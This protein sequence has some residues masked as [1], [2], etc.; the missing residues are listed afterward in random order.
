MSTGDPSREAI[1]HIDSNGDGQPESYA[2]PPAIHFGPEGAIERQNYLLPSTTN[3]GSAYTNELQT[4]SFSSPANYGSENGRGSPTYSI[5][6]PVNYDPK[7]ADV[8]RT[9]SFSQPANIGS[10]GVDE[11]VTYSSP[12]FG[13]AEPEDI[14]ES[15]NYS[16]PPHANH[17]FE[18]GRGS[19]VLSLPPPAP[20]SD[21]SAQ[22]GSMGYEG[23][24]SQIP[25]RF[26]PQTPVSLR[27]PQ[28][29]AE[30]STGSEPQANT[31]PYGWMS[32]IDEHNNDDDLHDPAKPMRGSF[33][34]TRAVVNVGTLILLVL[35]LLML[36]AGYPILH[37]YT[38]D[39]NDDDRLKSF[40]QIFD[41]ENVYP[42]NAPFLRMN[43]SKLQNN[44]DPSKV[45][46]IDPDTP[47]EAYTM[48]STFTGMDGKEFKL[49]FSD[50]FNTDGRSFYPGEDP[51][52]EAV[53][54]HY[55]ATNNYEWYDPAAIYTS[56]GSLRI[57]LE[58]HP[59]HN[60]NFRAGML[61]SWNKFCFRNGILV[62]RIQ[63]PGYSDVRGLWPAF[64]IMGNLGRAGYGATLQGTWPYSHDQCDV[65]TVMNQTL[66]NATYPDGFPEGTTDL[67]GATVFNMKHNTRALSFLP[68]QKLSRC[69]C[70]G[71]DHPGPFKNGQFTGRAAPEIDV[72]EA[73]VGDV[74]DS[75]TKGMTVS[76]S[77][78]MAPYNWQYDITEYNKSEAVRLFAQ[79]SKLN[80]YN[81]EI[82]Q[83]SLS[84]VSPAS[85]EAIQYAAN[86]TDTE[87]G[88]A[89]AEYALEYKGG[90][91][92]YVSW[93]THGKKAWEI[94]KDA[95]VADEKSQV[96]NRQFPREPLYILL[97]LGISRNFG[98][99]K[100]YKVI[101]GFPFEMAVDWV[102][103]YQDP[104]DPES[105]IGCSPDD[106]PTAEYINR[107][108]EAYTNPNLTVWGGSRDEGGY[109]AY[110]P[111]NR[112]YN[113]GNG[114]KTDRS[115]EPG[116]PNP[117]YRRRAPYVPSSSV[118][119]VPG[120]QTDYPPKRS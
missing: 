93:L 87:D 91:N 95:L 68:G 63:L 99:F 38:E 112:L 2:L 40:K 15:E 85:Q 75:G 67:G 43:D 28:S 22:A 72:F 46:F 111:K 33:E 116:D 120:A 118:T 98:D 62:G 104:D 24:S 53:D 83:Q 58:Q 92:G 69:T 76:Q 102:R 13:H 77:C 94:Y 12:A 66:W 9:N 35:C 23:V 106:M 44:F 34:P 26:S 6:P 51:F 7:N 97:N 78:Q 48:K 32:G 82:T 36:F 59:E 117:S 25:G 107:H 70:P 14:K 55:W 3:Y 20:F 100:W 17:G 81:G 41:G 110:W 42:S 39:K 1:V 113:D 74:D 10:K 119:A 88:T 30:Q 31:V 65:G 105:D 21:R 54:L 101:P 60:L 52:W 11:T 108:M 80:S 19:D 50:E 56:N 5:T 114:C 71:E 115:K 4:T 90:P 45:M 27:R 89:F 73:Q 16:L 86:T 47:K 109:G 8:S 79:Y 18:N 84:G 49:V 96:G 103:I 64:W 29:T 37:Y 57:R 61:Q